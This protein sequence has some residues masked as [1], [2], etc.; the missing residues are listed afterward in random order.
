M[1]N[2]NMFADFSS[3]LFFQQW[4][5]TVV[6]LGGS[7]AQSTHGERAASG[8]ARIGRKGRKELK[9]ISR[10]RSSRQQM[11]G[12]ERVCR[13]CR[14]LQQLKAASASPKMMLK[15]VHLLGVLVCGS[16]GRDACVSAWNP[17][18]WWLCGQVECICHRDLQQA[19]RA[20]GERAEDERDR[21]RAEVRER[22]GLFKWTL[23]CSWGTSS[24][25]R[26]L[27]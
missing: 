1:K 24:G 25:A 26:T 18:A 23:F 6:M 3:C 11:N 14:F 4:G 19:E 27:S 2:I 22:G 16:Q 20:A 13:P 9:Q 5:W 15:L 10:Q 7:S 21:G 8:S 12:A 17:R